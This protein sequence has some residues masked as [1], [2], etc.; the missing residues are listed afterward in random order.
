M[1]RLTAGLGAGVLALSLA[2]AAAPEVFAQDN[3]QRQRGER[4]GGQR[5]GQ[6]GQM[7]ERMKT[8]VYKLDLTAAQK[9]KVDKLFTDTQAEMTKLRQAGGS[10]EETRTKSREMMMKFR[11]ELTSILT[12]DQQKK[13][14]E[15]MPRR[16]GGM[17]RPGGGQR[18][19]Q[20]GPRQGS[21]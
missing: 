20:R 11:T 18:Q 14:Q 7:L 12:A 5:G 1:K 3:Q 9:P 2:L 16:G 8:E 19:R 13:L 6:R 4:Q 10:Q 21:A 17:G 15:A